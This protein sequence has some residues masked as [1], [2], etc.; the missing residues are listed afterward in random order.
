MDF[1][2][3]LKDKVIALP[4][5]ITYTSIASTPSDTDPNRALRIA[6]VGHCSADKGFDLFIELANEFAGPDLEFWAI[7]RES[8]ALP[9]QALEKLTHRPTKGYLSSEEY[10]EALAGTDIVLLPLAEQYRYVASGSVLDAISALKPIITIENSTYRAIADE[11]GSFGPMLENRG[12]IH[13]LFASLDEERFLPQKE[14]WLK[15]LLAIRS[16]RAPE[17]LAIKYAKAVLT[18]R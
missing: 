1:A 11:Y 6:F 9:E 4:H 2:S 17:K 10:Y 3:A 14:M 16:A 18:S 12:A 15:A 5:P 8:E 13:A 7:G